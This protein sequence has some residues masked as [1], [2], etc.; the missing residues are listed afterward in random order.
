MA[1][2]LDDVKK[3][4]P[5]YKALIVCLIYI[6]L[7]Y[8]YYFYFL[9]ADLEKRGTLQAKLQELEQQV[10]SKERLAAEMGKYSKGVDTLKGEFKAALNKLPVRKEVPELLHAVALSGKTAGMSFILFEPQATVKKPIGG[11]KEEGEKPPEKK[12]ADAKGQP[13]KPAE[14]E[15]Y[16]EE[17]PVKVVINGGYRNTAVFFEKVAKLPRIINIEDISMGDAKPVKGKQLLTASCII[18]T[19]MFVQKPGEKGKK[20][21]EKKP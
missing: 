8:F 13:A 12:P 4:S 11:K 5:K 18:K 2:T 6:V 15:E 21:D 9:Q 20:T 19:Y 7:G 14:E 3:L 10:S 16:Y 17:I 1:M